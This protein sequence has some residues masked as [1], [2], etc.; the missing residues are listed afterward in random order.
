MSDNIEQYLTNIRKQNRIFPHLISITV[1]CLL[2]FILYP[3]TVPIF[4]DQVYWMIGGFALSPLFILLPSNDLG[5][6]VQSE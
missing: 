2:V 4:K 3:A 6:A 5:K 1:L